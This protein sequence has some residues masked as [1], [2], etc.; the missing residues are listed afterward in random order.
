MGHRGPGFDVVPH[1][2]PGASP[3]WAFNPTTIHQVIQ[4]ITSFSEGK[5]TFMKERKER[6]T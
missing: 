1:R 6:K 3:P 4:V 2:G 5:G